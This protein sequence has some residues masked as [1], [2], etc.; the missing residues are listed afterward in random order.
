MLKTREHHILPRVVLQDISENVRFILNYV[1]QTIVPEGDHEAALPNFSVDAAFNAIG[2]DYML[3]Q[4]CASRLGLVAPQT[5]VLGQEV[6]NGKICKHTMQYVPVLEILKLYLGHNDVWTS[7]NQKRGQRANKDILSGY[8][9]GLHFANSDFFQ[10]NPNAIRILLYA[11]EFEVVNP[12]GAKRGRHKL[13]AVYFVVEN[14][15]AKFRATLKNIHLAILVKYKHV[16]RYGYGPVF[17]PLI[18]DL[19]KLETEG[20]MVNVNGQNHHRVGTVVALCADNLSSHSIGGFSCSFGA[21]RI[22]RFCM[23]SKEEISV[24]SDESEYVLRTKDVHDYHVNAVEGNRN[25]IPIYGVN[26][27]CCSE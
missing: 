12:L 9:S 4:Y 19:K 14:V 18:A 2:S 21:G 3:N 7:A 26:G 13:L 22:C 25:N 20:F 8:T 10:Q 15:E 11:D 27:Q 16:Q 17:R 5:F 1:T 23:A 6:L 24:N